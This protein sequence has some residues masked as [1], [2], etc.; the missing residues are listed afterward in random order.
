M[1]YNHVLER[2]LFMLA[3]NNH[4]LYCGVQKIVTPVIAVSFGTAFRG[5]REYKLSYDN[6]EDCCVFEFTEKG[7]VYNFQLENEDMAALAW[8]MASTLLLAKQREA[9]DAVEEFAFYLES[10]IE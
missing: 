7:T 9:S 2:A 5:I 4:P 8:R 3:C 10:K 1:N 6:V